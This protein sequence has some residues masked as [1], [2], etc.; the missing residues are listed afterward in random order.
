VG[1]S[2]KLLDNMLMAIHLKRGEHVY[3]TNV[4]KCL[5]PEDRTRM[6]TRSHNACRICNA[7]LN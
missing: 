4:V 5:P 2:G 3:I 6:L 7:R 1:Q